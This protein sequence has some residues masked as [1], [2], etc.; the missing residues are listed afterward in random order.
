MNKLLSRTIKEYLSRDVKILKIAVTIIFSAVFFLANYEI[1]GLFGYVGAVTVAFLISL[2]FS[3]I[4]SSISIIKMYKECAQLHG[5]RNISID[6]NHGMFNPDTPEPIAEL[7]DAYRDSNP[8]DKDFEKF[9][10]WVQE[11]QIHILC[12]LK[13]KGC[14]E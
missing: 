6:N 7:Y 8:D 4:F 13:C 3:T 10:E 1:V 9:D 11:N 12:F 14:L 2:V 5:Q